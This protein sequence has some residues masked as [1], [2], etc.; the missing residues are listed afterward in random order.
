MDI[1]RSGLKEVS[2]PNMS[3]LSR[4]ILQ[5]IPDKRE[6]RSSAIQSFSLFSAGK[7]GRLITT[8]YTAYM[9]PNRSAE[10][11]LNTYRY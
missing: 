5:G 1:H 6:G 4:Y 8:D 10:T 2:K 11:G 3:D 9:R 7:T